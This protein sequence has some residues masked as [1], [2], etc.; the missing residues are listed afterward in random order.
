MIDFDIFTKIAKECGRF[1]QINCCQS[2]QKVGQ[3]PINC[4]SG[5]TATDRQVVSQVTKVAA[6]HL[7]I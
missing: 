1:G 3:S 5:H 2:L 4:L 6:A 7:A